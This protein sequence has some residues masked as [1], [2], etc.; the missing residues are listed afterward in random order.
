MGAD[1]RPDNCMADQRIANRVRPIFG[2]RRLRSSDHDGFLA[3]EFMNNPDKCVA[4]YDIFE[5]V[6]YVG[7]GQ[8][9]CNYAQFPFCLTRSECLELSWRM[10]ES[11]LYS[12]AYAPLVFRTSR[13]AGGVA[14]PRCMS[15]M[16][17]ADP[18]R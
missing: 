2:Q 12:D 4:F 13:V 9:L 18:T 15:L 10:V 1:G 17:I 8:G 7:A 11:H 5:Q 14:R 16:A 3:F 6:G